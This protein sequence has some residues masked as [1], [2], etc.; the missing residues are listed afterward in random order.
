M[1]V[2]TDLLRDPLVY[3]LA[4]AGQSAD[5]IICLGPIPYVARCL[6]DV[7]YP[8]DQR[9]VFPV[10][11]AASAAGLAAAPRFPMLAR[12]TAVM[13]TVYF[14][15]AVGAHVRARDLRLNFAAASSLLLFYAALAAT[16]PRPAERPGP[17]AER[18]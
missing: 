18:R 16:G 15:L 2:P 17:R 1:N 10:V 3:R 8:A 11:K 6:D 9:W 13:L 5:A 12:F 7:G 14:C 4:A